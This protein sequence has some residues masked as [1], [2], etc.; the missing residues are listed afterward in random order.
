VRSGAPAGRPVKVC[1]G[2]PAGRPVKVCS[3]GARPVRVCSGVPAG[4]PVRVC[5]GPAAGR[6]VKVCSG[7]AG[8]RP[9][10]AWTGRSD[11]RGR[12][13]CSGSSV[14]PGW[15][16][17][18]R[19]SSCCS[20]GPAGGTGGGVL[21]RAGEEWGDRWAG[22]VGGRS[23]DPLVV[24]PAGRSVLPGAP[25]DLGGWTGPGGGAG[26]P[27]RGAP[28]N[29][30]GGMLGWVPA[31]P[32]GSGGRR[33]AVGPAGR[34][35]PPGPGT[36]GPGPDGPGP[37]GPGPAGPEAGRPG[38]GPAGL[39]ED[40]VPGPASPLAPA[41][42]RRPRGGGG[43]GGGAAGSNSDVPVGCAG[44][45]DGSARGT[46]LGT[47]GA[48]GDPGAW[49]RPEGPGGPGGPACAPDTRG[50]PTSCFESVSDQPLGPA[51][52]QGPLGQRRAVPGRCGEAAKL[53]RSAAASGHVL[54]IS[55]PLRLLT[56][57]AVVAFIA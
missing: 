53:T 48:S 44:R 7:P 30:P 17:R 6:P 51:V 15:R 11:R 5:S 20:R 9:L 40:G 16:G 50:P 32:G 13:A 39:A 8:W 1:S 47:F 42:R 55:Q 23:G 14:P 28:V 22:P 37:D 33:P 56:V 10:P 19:G 54:W 38:G 26:W 52:A 27:R 4:R 3:A 21:G 29:A 43:T 57:N 45:A 24:G 12:P 36:D 49:C 35:G 2:V 46:W 41:A 34:A 31:R 18:R 25:P